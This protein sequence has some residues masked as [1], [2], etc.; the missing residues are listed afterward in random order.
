MAREK[1]ILQNLRRPLLRVAGKVT[2][3]VNGRDQNGLGC[4]LLVAAEAGL[5]EAMR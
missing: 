4:C 5:Y 2:I 1:V 3:H